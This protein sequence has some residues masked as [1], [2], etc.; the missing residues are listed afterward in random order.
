MKRIVIFLLFL[1]TVTLTL[2]PLSRAANPQVRFET[3][4]GNFTVELFE[5]EAPVTVKNFLDYVRDGYYVDTTFHR[6]I[7]GFMAQGGGY[8]ANQQKKPGQRPPIK[9]EAANGLKN[10]RGTI[11]MARTNMVDSATS[12]FF[13][14]VVNND[15]LNHV[16]NT[17]RG[18]GYCVFGKVVEGMDVVDKIVNA[19]QTFKNMVFQNLPK[20]PII[21]KKTTLLTPKVEAETK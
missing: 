5:K 13:I 8:L 19:P 3:T 4:M 16:D 20:E 17:P 18:F 7:P 14:N 10:D 6:I 9:N 1:V 21:I 15:F 2:P 11:A 12:E